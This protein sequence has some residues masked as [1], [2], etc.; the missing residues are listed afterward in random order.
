MKLFITFLFTAFFFSQGMAQKEIDSLKNIW[1]NTSSKD[2]NRLKALRVLIKDH[3]LYAKTDSALIL[4]TEMINYAQKRKNIKY[5]IEAQT[6]LGEIYFVK[7]DNKSATENYNKGLE[8]AKTIKDS[9]LFANKLFELGTLYYD[10]DDYT[11]AFKIFQ[12]SQEI[13]RL[14]GDS[15]NEG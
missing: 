5:E 13:C 3:Y 7:K 11:N 10:Y 15:L 2:S 14:V 4:T 8:L 1:Y 9:V 12:K 6:L